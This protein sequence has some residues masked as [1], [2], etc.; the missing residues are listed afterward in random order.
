LF[1]WGIGSFLELYKKRGILSSSPSLVSPLAST[2][3][4]PLL[5][6]AFGQTTGSWS[7]G[8]NTTV[9]AIHAALT[10]TGKIFYLAALGYCINNENGPYTAR[11]LDPTTGTE[12]IVTLSDDLWCGGA[13]QLSN[14]NIFVCGGTKLYDTDVNN[15]NGRCNGLRDDVPKTFPNNPHEFAYSMRCRTGNLGGMNNWFCIFYSLTALFH[16]PSTTSGA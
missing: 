7:L 13:A 5:Q 4:P 14:G 9:V 2:P 6:T 8:Q 1:R 16:F 11:L 3:I 12:T 10:S 15:C